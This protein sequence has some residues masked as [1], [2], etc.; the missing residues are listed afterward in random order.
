MKKSY[1]IKKYILEV[2]QK[3]LENQQLKRNVKIEYLIPLL[4]FFV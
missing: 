4:I 1:M 2:I 3:R